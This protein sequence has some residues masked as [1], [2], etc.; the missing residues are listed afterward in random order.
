MYLILS[1]KSE[2]A[3]RIKAVLG[4]SG[5]EVTDRHQLLAALDRNP[6]LIILVI[7]PS[8]AADQS[9]TIATELRS[10]FPF[11]NAILL[12][13]HLDVPTFSAALESGIKEVIDAQ[14]ATGLLSAVRRCE[15]AAEQLTIGRFA[16]GMA[17]K[18]GKLITVYSA[19]GG[20]GKT[21][22]ATNLAVLLAREGIGRICLVDL[23]LEFGDVAT[24][25]RVSPDRSIA[26]TTELNGDI[27]GESLSKA[28]VNFDERLDLLLA[29]SDP[30]EISRITAVSITRIL[31]LL[32]RDYEYVVVDTAPTMS[33]I[34]RQ[35]LRESDL[36]LLLTT[37]DMPAIKNLKIA[38][39]ILDGF[40]LGVE[41][42]RIILNRADSK[43]GL[44]SSDVEE[45]IGE[46]VALAVPSNSKVT[47]AVN[48][49]RPLALA[50]PHNTV[51]RSIEE[52]VEIVRSL[53]ERGD[54]P[55]L[56]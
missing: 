41:R 33:A 21:T 20:S 26:A 46:Q 5:I 36:A 48:D 49:G 2:D 54:K 34:M 9:F 52:L 17:P 30:D 6:E 13:S 31:A 11:L 18:R 14:D 15:S 27:D 12:R 45:L 50:F 3:T 32:Q 43:V 29:P 1:E 53:M 56:V 22:I 42:R 23:D 37:L 25:F 24:V 38:L 28:I 51:S 40:G 44:T 10:L 39:A 8:V 16:P 19:K 4:P 35:T 7:A 47:A 55:A